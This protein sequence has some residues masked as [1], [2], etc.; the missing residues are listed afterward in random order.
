ML[1]DESAY[2]KTSVAFIKFLEEHGHRGYNEF[3]VYQRTWG[4]NPEP[5]VASLQTMMRSDLH[6]DS[7]SKVH[8][9]VWQSVN[10][11]HGKLTFWQK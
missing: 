9:S 8:E 6:E 5:V 10:S 1:R 7:S 4:V 3:D 2:P 11:I